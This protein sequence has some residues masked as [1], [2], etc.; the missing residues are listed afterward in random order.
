MKSD[1]V[2]AYSQ[3][4]LFFLAILEL[5]F[6]VQSVKYTPFYVGA[7]YHDSTLFWR[8]RRDYD[9]ARGDI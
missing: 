5:L 3:A 4:F 2:S 8:E 9:E 7:E 1:S 6:P